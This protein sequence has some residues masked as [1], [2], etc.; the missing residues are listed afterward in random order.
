MKLFRSILTLLLALTLSCAHSCDKYDDSSLRS[1]LDGIETQ[2]G[3]NAQALEQIQ[4]ALLHAGKEGLTAVVSPVEGGSKVTF[5]DGTSF[6]I[7]DGQDGP[8][9]PEGPQGQQGQQGLQGEQ[10]PQG[11]AG[12]GSED[13]TFTETQTEYI[14]TIDGQEYVVAKGFAIILEKTV[15]AISSEETVEIAYHLNLSDET[16]EIYASEQGGFKVSIDKAASKISI[17]ASQSIDSEGHITVTAVKNSTGEQ[18]AQY[19]SLEKSFNASFSAA[20]SG[21]CSLKERLHLSISETGGSTVTV[22]WGDGTKTQEKFTSK[23]Y[24]HQFTAPGE[25]TVSV[26]ENGVTKSWKVTVDSLLALSEALAD[27]KASNKI[28]FM[29]HRSHTSDPYIPENSVAAVNAAVEAGVDVIETDTH[30]TSDGYVVICHD[31]TV[32]AT[33]NG[34][35]DITTM[36]LAQIKSL[37]LLDR[38]GNVTSEK[39]P[40]LEEFLLAARGRAYVNLDYSPRTASTGQVM[41]I[42]ERLGMVQQV[43]MYCNTA[44][45]IREVYDYDPYAIAYCRCDYYQSLLSGPYTYMVQARWKPNR[46]SDVIT[47]MNTTRAAVGAGCISTVNMLHVNV[48]SI[49]EYD[50]D[51]DY[52]DDLLE[53]YPDCRMIQN[54]CPD[55]LIPILES[56]GLR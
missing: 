20:Q 41:E 12:A 52:L 38:K 29:A 23:T 51:L 9:G 40:T 7:Y 56:M 43:L 32:N 3:R 2:A 5:S 45:F 27:L 33:T 42:V 15:I 8:Q 25:Y 1:R 36:T 44:A 46:P 39:M 50:I 11:Q 28:W 13:I 34:R 37:Y 49:P 6:V 18:S 26:S 54:D 47:D 22:D 31:Q 21:Y 16:T 30:I 10:G 19:I 53:C 14:F 35:G 24:E 48:S 4:Y 17:T 55:I